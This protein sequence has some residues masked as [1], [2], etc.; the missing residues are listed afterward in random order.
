[1]QLS[2]GVILEPECNFIILW[3]TV[4]GKEIGRFGNRREAVNS[5]AWSPDGKT[6]AGARDDSTIQLWDAPSGQQ[7]RTL[8]G[9]LAPITSVSFSPDGRRLATGSADTT[10]LIWDVTGLEHRPKILLSGAELT[11][12]WNDL[13]A[14]YAARAYRAVWRLTGDSEAAVRFLHKQLTAPAA[15]PDPKQ[16]ASLIADL[17]SNRFSVRQTASNELASLEELAEPALRQAL[18]NKP[19]PEARRRLEALLDR[20]QTRTLP[21]EQ[22]RAVR[23]VAVL[24]H[25]ASP[26]ARRLLAA[27]AKGAPEARL[28]QEAKASLERLTRRPT[29]P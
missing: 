6:L 29:Q 22:L 18:A 1:M 4:T 24:E 9:Q 19:S 28:T 16:L 13:A 8:S 12:L 7:I 20:I 25:V 14:E 26:E 3:D 21:S 11:A 27:L 17:D 15:A 5:V 23:A 2:E 10:C